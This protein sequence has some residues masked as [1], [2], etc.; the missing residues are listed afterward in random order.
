MCIFL[1]A[2]STLRGKKKVG[3]CDVRRISWM[4][5]SQAAIRQQVLQYCGKIS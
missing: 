2:I 1:T 5:D 4:V 3:W